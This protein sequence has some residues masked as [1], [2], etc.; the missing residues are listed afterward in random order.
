MPE[1]GGCEGPLRS[2]AM[3]LIG[4]WRRRE[5]GLNKG[6]VVCFSETGKMILEAFHKGR[7]LGPVCYRPHWPMAEG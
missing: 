7:D 4:L 1:L 2:K 6:E 3:N 5:T